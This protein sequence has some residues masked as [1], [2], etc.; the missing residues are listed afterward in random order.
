MDKDEIAKLFGEWQSA[1]R[2]ADNIGLTNTYGLSNEDRVDLDIQFERAE[3]QATDAYLAYRR[4][5]WE[6]ANA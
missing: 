4:A 5:I 2:L 6:A 3:R 1:R